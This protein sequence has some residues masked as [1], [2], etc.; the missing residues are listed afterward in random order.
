MLRDSGTG[1]QVDVIASAAPAITYMRI[2][3]W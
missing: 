2:K 1:K 3:P